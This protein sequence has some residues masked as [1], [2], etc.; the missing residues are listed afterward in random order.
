MNEKINDE[1]N[2]L[3]QRASGTMLY[4]SLL[5]VFAKFEIFNE[6]QKVVEVLCGTLEVFLKKML[7]NSPENNQIKIKQLLIQGFEELIFRLKE[8]V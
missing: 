5:E 1:L 4:I 6:P 3:E 7:E 2:N 8:N